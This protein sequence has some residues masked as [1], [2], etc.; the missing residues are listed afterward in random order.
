VIPLFRLVPHSHAREHELGI[1]RKTRREIHVEVERED[2]FVADTGR[3]ADEPFNAYDGCG[4]VLK[5]ASMGDV[6]E[7][8]GGDE[9]GEEDDD[10]GTEGVES[11][12]RRV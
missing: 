6:G 2:G 7:G 3:R 10:V 1:P 11:V 8:C 9:G 5:I 12:E 4:C